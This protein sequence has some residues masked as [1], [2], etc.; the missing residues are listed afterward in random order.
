MRMKP[1]RNTK[2]EN[3]PNIKWVSEYIV[4]TCKRVTWEDKKELRALL[5]FMADSLY[6]LDL[7]MQILYSNDIIQ[8]KNEALR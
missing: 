4:D 7:P 6:D 8:L 2:W 3:K 1:I 5:H